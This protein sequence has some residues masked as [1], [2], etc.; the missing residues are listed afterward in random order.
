MVLFHKIK[1]KPG[2]EAVRCGIYPTKSFIPEPMKG[3]KFPWLQLVHAIEKVPVA[4]G[5]K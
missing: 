5:I 3:I 1:K 4:I 2:S